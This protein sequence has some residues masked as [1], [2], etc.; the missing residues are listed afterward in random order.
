MKQQNKKILPFLITSTFILIACTEQ[1]REVI[2]LKAEK[3][4]TSEPVTQD[5]VEIP[6]TV[7]STILVNNPTPL[8]QGYQVDTTHLKKP[9]MIDFNGDGKLDA[10]RVL[11]NPNKVGM[12]Y[13]FEFRI[14]DSDKVYWYEDDYGDDL[15]AFGVFELAPKTEIYA[16]EEHRF[17]KNGSIRV[18]EEIDPKYYLKFKGDGISVNVLEE[19]C[20]TSVFFLEN[21]KIRRIHLC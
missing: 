3:Q 7:K 4:V 18:N 12:K 6:P 9:M 13:L 14:A 20:A 15:D 2:E 5:V 19:T 1:P 11:K 8:P 16:D 10:F 17:D 21:E